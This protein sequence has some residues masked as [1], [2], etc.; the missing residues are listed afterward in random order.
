MITTKLFAQYYDQR[1]I[2]I[3]II[4]FKND[5]TKN[6]VKFLNSKISD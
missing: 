5:I 6:Q 2:D 1:Y 3:M 4:N